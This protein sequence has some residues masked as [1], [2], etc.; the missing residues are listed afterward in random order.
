MSGFLGMS[1]DDFLKESPPV[2]EK[3]EVS[4]PASTAAVVETPKEDEGTPVTEPV[5][6]DVVV[7][8]KSDGA[9]DDD[10]Q[11]ETDPTVVATQPKADGKTQVDPKAEP[12]AEELAA[13]AEEAKK[14]PVVETPKVIDYKAEYERLMKPLKANGKDIELRSPDELVKLAQQGANYTQKMQALAPHRKI[15]L[16]L[17]NNGLLDETKLNTLIDLD[18]KNPEA[19][20]QL[21]LDAGI[22]PLDLDPELKPQYQPG[23]HTVSDQEANFNAVLDNHKHN[24]EGRATLAICNTWDQASKDLLWTNPEIIDTMHEQRTSGVYD[25][26]ANEVERQKMLGNIPGHTPFLEA[27][28]L[29][30]DQMVAGKAATV[31]TAPV[32]VARRAAAPTAEV[33]NNAKANAA[34]APRTTAK[35][36]KTVVNPLSMSDEEFMKQFANRL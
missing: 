25:L 32:P 28:K 20:K 29:V 8:P 33:A 23:N 21:M 31:Q 27:Y 3:Q 24:E 1:D 18:K 13:Q 4:T 11:D 19:I 35:S 22:N 34:A 5:V 10:D 9:K 26:I 6:A 2:V 16:M 7:D 15:L 36:A 14:N 17:Q 30:G 12:T